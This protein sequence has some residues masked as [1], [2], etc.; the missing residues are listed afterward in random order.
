MATGKH[1]LNCIWRRFENIL[2]LIVFFKNYHYKLGI[3]MGSFI[4]AINLLEMHPKMEI[5]GLHFKLHNQVLCISAKTFI[6][7]VSGL[8]KHDLQYKNPKVL[9]S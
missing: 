4:T 9:F 6:T 5:M 7:F 1:I 3:M 8:E 2:C